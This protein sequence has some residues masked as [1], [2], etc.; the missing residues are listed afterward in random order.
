MICKTSYIFL[1]LKTLIFI[2]LAVVFYIV[3]CHDVLN[4]FAEN[5]T[6]VINSQENI[7][8][9]EMDPPF[10]TFC[11]SP[12]AKKSILEGY[13]LSSA[14][15][16]E[17]NSNEQKILISL[18][19]T[20]ETLFREVTF[21]LNRD[22]HMSINLWFYEDGFGWL[23]YTGK[24]KEGSGNYIQVLCPQFLAEQLTLSQ[25]G[26]KIMPTTVLIALPD[27]QTLQWP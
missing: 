4:K 13:N 20:V 24:M 10:I 19:K 21:K 25:P 17:P 15:L 11:M 9:N 5:D 22:F 27:F 23:N 2:C 26:D 18:N 1:L 6:T 8:E 12:R 16:N 7:E 14:V 3:Y